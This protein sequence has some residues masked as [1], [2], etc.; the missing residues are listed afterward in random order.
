M[1]LLRCPISV[2]HFELELTVFKALQVMD[3][4]K[5]VQWLD[6]LT[7]SLLQR[8]L[9]GRSPS[10]EASVMF[11]AH[12]MDVGVTERKWGLKSSTQDD[13]DTS[14]TAHKFL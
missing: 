12:T 8:D 11:K 10:E 6:C 3:A 2:L 5:Y 13:V 14:T 9:C 7:L 1:K 4:F